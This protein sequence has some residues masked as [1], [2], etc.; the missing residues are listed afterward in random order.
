[1]VVVGLDIGYGNTKVTFS[2]GR[3][4]PVSVVRPSGA[5]PREKLMDRLDGNGKYVGHGIEVLV[6]GSPWVAGIDSAQI[7][8]GFAREMSADYPQSRDY[9]ALYFGALVTVGASKVDHLITGLPVNEYSDSARREALVRRLRGTHYVGEGKTV[10]VVKVTVLPQPA[11]AYFDQVSRWL[12]H[13]VESVRASKPEFTVLAVDLGHYS[14]DWVLFQGQTVASGKSASSNEAGFRVIQQVLKQLFE[15]TG[16]RV[17]AATVESAI[18]RG[19]STIEVGSRS[20]P[21]QPLLDAAA[22][23]VVEQVVKE[24]MG[25]LG[26]QRDA[27]NKVILAGGGAPF[28]LKALRA[29][30]DADQVVM[31]PESILANARGFWR[32]GSPLGLAAA[33]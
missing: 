31:P 19:D 20:V 13:P 5:A 16:K 17:R 10:E 2:V 22:N 24:M 14:T 4:E 7:Q 1:M 8:S 9:L 32:F 26:D 12:T 23:V 27:V 28:L 15:Q 6:D 29:R 18:R 30:F 11:G 25:Q 21:L 33:A 3:A